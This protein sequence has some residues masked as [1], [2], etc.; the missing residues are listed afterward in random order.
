MKRSNLIV[1]L[2]LAVFIVGAAATYLVLREDDS[3]AA[4]AAGETAVLYAAQAIPAGTGGSAALERGLVKTKNV[5]ADAR[6]AGA[7]TDPSQLTGKTAVAAIAEGSVLTS[8]QF[9]QAQTRLGTLKIPQ[10]KT[11]LALKLG[12]IQ[13]VAGFAQAGDRIDLFGVLKEGSP[14]GKAQLV[15]Q[16]TEVLSVSA[17]TA[18]PGQPTVGEPIFLLAV[19]PTEAERLVYLTTFQSL[20]FSLVPRDQAPVPATPGSGRPDALKLRP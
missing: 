5:E 11:A 4:P 16:N 3:G 13:G 12:H 6:P 1:A 10:G 14:G 17:A 7:L 20:Y 15:M 18:S 2:G 19:N 8:E 9:P